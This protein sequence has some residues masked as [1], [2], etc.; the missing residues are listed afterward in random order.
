MITRLAG[1]YQ[2]TGRHTRKERTQL[3]LSEE[4]GGIRRRLHE[5]RADPRGGDHRS[6]PQ[7]GSDE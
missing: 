3:T 4:A 6:A 1:G 7:E 5:K 2:L